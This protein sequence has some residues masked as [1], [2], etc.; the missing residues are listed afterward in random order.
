M[1]AQPA[2]PCMDSSS[3]ER[4]CSQL[5]GNNLTSVTSDPVTVDPVVTS[6]AVVPMD[7]VTHEVVAPSSEAKVYVS[8]SDVE[9][10]RKQKISGCIQQLA[11]LLQLQDQ[12]GKMVR[13]DWV[14]SLEL[15]E[16]PSQQLLVC[17][18]L[19]NKERLI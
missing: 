19:L 17:S 6:G 13:Q 8:H 16:V 10:K 15:S 7:P 4:L 9:K 11:A 3:S 12:V 1:A 18:E 5:E 14:V 2:P